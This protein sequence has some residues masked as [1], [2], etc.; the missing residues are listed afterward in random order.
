M[1]EVISMD[2]QAGSSRYSY[3]GIP[4]GN[5]IRPNTGFVIPATESSKPTEQGAKNALRLF[6]A[7]MTGSDKKELSAEAKA[8]EA[9]YKVF[10]VDGEVR[11]GLVNYRP[12]L[13]ASQVD[14]LEAA[15][16]AKAKETKALTNKA[17]KAA[18]LDAKR[19]MVNQ[20]NAEIAEAEEKEKET[21]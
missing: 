1:F 5:L 8:L 11:V 14:I 19:E 16:A 2:V 15:A 21:A 10:S 6:A 13:P 17:K 3:S 20:L 18:T 9:C 12:D 7:N 4:F